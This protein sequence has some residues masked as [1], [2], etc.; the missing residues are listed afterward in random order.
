VAA[1]LTPAGRLTVFI[2]DTVAAHRSAQAVLRRGYR[3]GISV[4]ER[5]RY[6]Q[7][8]EKTTAQALGE[9]FGV[10][11]LDEVLLRTAHV[12][13]LPA[14]TAA[15][16]ASQ[17]QE[18]GRLVDKLPMLG[19]AMEAIFSNLDTLWVELAEPF[20]SCPAAV[21]QLRMCSD[22]LTGWNTTKN[23]FHITQ[24]IQDVRALR[25][26]AHSLE[27]PADI[28]DYVDGLFSMLLD[29]LAFSKY[30]GAGVISESLERLM[31]SLILRP[32]AEL[33]TIKKAGA[34]RKL[35]KAAE[36]TAVLLTGIAATIEIVHSIPSQPAPQ[37]TS[38]Q[39]VINNDNNA[40]D[41]RM[42]M[43]QPWIEHDPARDADRGPR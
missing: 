12:L 43:D 42:Y 24:L 34:F 28:K 11:E 15:L 33:E 19:D 20:S 27:M 38:I 1:N 9:I 10:T 16:V 7:A 36:S 35:M 17:F 4:Q 41:G 6:E 29:A 14:L 21:E 3:R 30:G 13:K 39:I 32:P 18:H 31:G 22:I 23:E 25:E 37:D 40:L 2:D 26:E 8:T 5:E